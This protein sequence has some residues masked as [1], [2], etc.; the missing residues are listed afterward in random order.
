M[1]EAVVV[2]EL[3]KRYQPN[4]PP[5]VDGLSFSVA[6]G[7]VF[8]LLGPNGAGKTTTIGVL[9]TR[10]RATSGRAVVCGADV[11]RSPAAA[12][13]LLAVV[14][15]RVNLDRALT[16]RQN[17][18]FHSAYHRVSR[19]VR[20]KRADELLEQMGLKDFANAR[21]DFLS[22]GLA[23]RTMIA[24]A[25][26]HAP[27][28]LFLDE[29]SGGLDPQ[30]RLFVHDRI[31]ELKQAGVTV[32]VT[33]HD[34]DEAEKLCD[35]VGI[36]DHGKLLTLDTPAALTRTLPGSS[37]LTLVVA[38]GA[39]AE[40][41]QAALGNVADVERVE[42]LRA[43]GPPGGMPMFPG[44]PPMPVPDAPA[45]PDATLSFRL[46][47]GTAPANAV[48]MALKILTDL[49]CEVRDL[50]IGQPS[51]EDVFIHLTGREL[52]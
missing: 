2:E 20:T 27:K 43:G 3:V 40:D 46:Y 6:A 36:V 14:P 34:M 29:P 15:Q 38:A 32:V 48:P 52:R 37:T 12:R 45:D 26:M 18:L 30:S 47:T 22:G 11:V 21:T 16:V 5:A 7:E 24:R 39:P 42:R 28:V 25:L 19:S 33:T 35:R 17:L 4:M 49:R 44:M 8:G 31:A 10:V 13:Q 50:S 1:D 51:L 23:Q 41:V 9:T